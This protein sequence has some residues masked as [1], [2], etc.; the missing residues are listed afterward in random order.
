MKKI[1]LAIALLFPVLASAQT[2]DSLVGLG[3]PPSL[4]EEQIKLSSGNFSTTET[5][6]GTSLGETLY[7]KCVNVGTLPN[8]TTTT[9]AHGIS[10][11]ALADLRAAYGWAIGSINSVPL[12]FVGT[13]SDVGITVEATTISLITTGDFSAYTGYVCLEYVK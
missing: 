4:A 11:F 13:S 7:R 5:V 8:A 2:T 10:G 3:T 12:P 1:I 9:D 6:V